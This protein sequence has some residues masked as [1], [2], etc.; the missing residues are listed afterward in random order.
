[1]AAFACHRLLSYMNRVPSSSLSEH[2]I[3]TDHFLHDQL[4][5][6]SVKTKLKTNSIR[7][8]C[9]FLEN[10]ADTAFSAEIVANTYTV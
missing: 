2:C 6:Y 9:I 4:S 5:H 1:M 8:L 7:V 3:T 10:K